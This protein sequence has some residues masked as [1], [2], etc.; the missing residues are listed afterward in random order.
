MNKSIN[1]RVK[2]FVYLVDAIYEG[3]KILSISTQFKLN[4]LYK[5]KDNMI[6]CERTISRL[7]QIL[8]EKYIIDNF[9]NKPNL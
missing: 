5:Q 7:N 3:E 8:S 1:D 2:R 4:D 9:H 6:D